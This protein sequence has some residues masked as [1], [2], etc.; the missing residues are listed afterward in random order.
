VNDSPDLS[1]ETNEP[2]GVALA[3]WRRRMKVPG[4]TLGKRV[5]MSQA[6]IS[7]LETGAATPDPNDVRLL[8]QGLGLPNDEVERLVELA[9]HHNNQL[10]DWRPTHLGLADRQRDL[11]H[12]EAST[13]E[14]R[15]FQPAVVIGLLQTSEYA[16]AL[17]STF[18]T[19]LA[20]D[21]IADSTIAVSEAVAARMQRQHVLA[22][23]NRSFY[24]LMSESV[25]SNK[26]CRPAEMLGQ[27]ERLREVSEQ[28]NVTLRIVP[29]DADW[30]IAPFH[31]F[32]VMDDRCVFVDL[33]NT[34]L[35]SRGRRTVRNYRRV[36][37]AIERVG[38][39]DIAPLL[40]RYQRLYVSMLLPGAA[41]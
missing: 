31:G 27:I 15:I 11:R 9:E 22:E 12:L 10:I 6:K 25:L 41:V 34:S 28:E 30:P 36:F 39:T 7:R 35:M 4:Q 23:P 13:H 14:L 3:R 20:D 26:V 40:D 17:L 37:D 16:R 38:T 8:A 21:Q 18:Q 33:F 29:T 1:A 32:A 19:E 24:F 5:G 2:V